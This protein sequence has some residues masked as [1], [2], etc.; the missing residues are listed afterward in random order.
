MIP[1]YVGFD[2]RETCGFHVFCNSVLSRTNARVSFHPVRGGRVEG[3]TTFNPER[4]NV[5]RECGYRGWAIWAECDMMLRADIE[6]LMDYADPSYDVLVVKHDYKTKFRVKFLGQNN[7]DYPR[8]NWSSM[9]LINCGAAVW[10]RIAESSLQDLHRFKP[11]RDERIGSLPLEWNW[12]VSEYPYNPKAK[13]AH[14]TIGIPPFYPACD[15]SSEWF[16][17]M[18]AA[19][20]HE[21]WDD[22]VLESER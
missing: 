4:F 3:S 10:Q 6:E 19:V 22:T 21:H 13:L 16:N 12:L 18:R 20:S 7:P 17:E 14:F 8:K 11:M 5:A 9:M 15:Y 2:P 1:V